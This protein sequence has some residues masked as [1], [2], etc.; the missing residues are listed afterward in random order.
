MPLTS[1]DLVEHPL[2]FTHIPKTAGTSINFGLKKVFPDAVA[3]HLQRLTDSELK[4]RA[5]DRTIKV[6]A[7]HV[8]YNRSR[9]AFADSGRTP[10]YVTV[11]RDPI[12]R[13]LSAYSYAKGTPKERWYDLANS[14]DIDAFI[15]HMKKEQ[16]QFLVG[17][18][19]RFLC[20]E[21]RADADTAFRSL[22]DNFSLVGLQKN[23]DEFFFGLERLTGRKLPQ[24]TRQNQSSERVRRDALQPETLKTLEATTAADRKLYLR[25]L[26][27][28]AEL[29]EGGQNQEDG[30]RQA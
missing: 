10:C 5:A 8:A 2:F 19:C 26:L 4:E 23:L 24:P 11:L 15:R 28:L 7:G 1:L 25:T 9:A 20:P 14:L 3:F 30:E 12:E 27:W 16:P 6:Y 17:K 18:Q 22:K 21:G 29:S 13:I